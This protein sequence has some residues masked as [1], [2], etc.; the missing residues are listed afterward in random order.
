MP[1][2]P[3]FGPLA[4]RS[5]VPGLQP[6]QSLGP[7]PSRRPSPASDGCAA[8]GPV[9][10]RAGSPGGWYPD[11]EHGAQP[12]D[13]QGMVAQLA[14]AGGHGPPQ[15]PFCCQDGGGGHGNRCARCPSCHQRLCRGAKCHPGTAPGAPAAAPHGHGGVRG[16]AD[17]PQA[18][19]G[20][21]CRALGLAPATAA[22]P[23]PRRALPRAGSLFTLTVER[24]QEGGK[25]QRSALRILAVPGATGPCPEL[26]VR[27]LW[28]CAGAPPSPLSGCLLPGQGGPGTQR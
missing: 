1:A 22:A 5:P 10:A 25:C 11:A 27:E 24:E 16:P 19:R 4:S 26:Y 3:S 21:G 13:S 20:S 28:R 14:V 2:A 7:P 23:R 6:R 9:G 18:R 17:T 8:P 12:G 15:L